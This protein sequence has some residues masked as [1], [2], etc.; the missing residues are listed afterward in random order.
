MQKQNYAIFGASGGIG[1]SLAHKLSNEG[2]RVFLIG[3]DESKLRSLSQQL[4]QPYK[5]TDATDELAVA[6]ALDQISVESGPLDGV[7]CLVGSFFLKPL[8]LTT[9]NEFNE[10]MRINMTSAFCVTKAA[11]RTMLNNKKGSIVLCASTAA[12]VGLTS[13]E[14]ISAAKGAVSAFVRA[15]A[16]SYA[17]KGIRINAVAPGLTRTSL[18][19]PI[20]SNEASL[21]ASTAFHPLGRIG[22]PIDI[23]AAIHWLL[24]EESSWITGEIIAV[25]G[26][27]SS[28]RTKA[29]I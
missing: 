25:D 11:V 3:R 17:G 6:E 16:A 27:L 28:L 29:S 18:A 9:L 5:V 7:A 12:L 19:E 15:A 23:A 13:H 8:H 4:S 21:K 26:G 2:H 10:V 24:S 22:E 20:L 14:A 1:H